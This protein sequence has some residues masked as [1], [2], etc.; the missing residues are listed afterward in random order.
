VTSEIFR[1]KALILLASRLE[2]IEIAAEQLGVVGVMMS[3][4]VKGAAF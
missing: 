2:S 4:E 3:R 1:S